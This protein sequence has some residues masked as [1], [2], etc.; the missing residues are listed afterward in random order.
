MIRGTRILNRE[1][2]RR[3]VEAITTIRGCLHGRRL[4]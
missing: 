1:V 2:A 3:Y 4:R